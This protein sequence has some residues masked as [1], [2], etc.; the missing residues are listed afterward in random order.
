MGMPL[1]E[2]MGQ[3]GGFQAPYGAPP[4][5]GQMPGGPQAIPLADSGLRLA[6]RLLD[7]II[8]GLIGCVPGLALGGGSALFAGRGGSGGAA[9]SF[10]T[11]IASALVGAVIVLV[12]D[13]VVTAKLGGT[14]MKKAF[15]MQ[16]VNAAD[17]SPVN[18]QQALT[19]A[20]PSALLAAIPVIGWFIGLIMGIASLIMLFSDK[21]RQTVSDKVAKTVV[22]NRK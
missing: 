20:A 1:P 14:L 2:G 4:M 13:G 22:I 16:V 11:Q 15:G 18:M 21:M 10:G 19:R 6:A 9:V 5:M 12:Y 8:M 17:G 7:K 3:P